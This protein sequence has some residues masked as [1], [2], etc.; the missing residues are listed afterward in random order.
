MLFWIGKRAGPDCDVWVQMLCFSSQGNMI[1]L[2][3]SERLPNQTHL[4]YSFACFSVVLTLSPSPQKPTS[5][6]KFCQKT[7]TGFR[8]KRVVLLAWAITEVLDVWD[9]SPIKGSV[10]LSTFLHH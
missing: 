4:S 3:G 2:A 5:M 1:A 9:S 7:A 10:C 8:K 6:Q